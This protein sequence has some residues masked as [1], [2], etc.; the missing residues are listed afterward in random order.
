MNDKKLTSAYL[1]SRV[2]NSD[3]LLNLNI[4]ISDKFGVRDYPYVLIIQSITKK[5]TRLTIYP[6]KK[7]R[8]LKISLFGQNIS[9]DVI[10]ILSKI[11]KNYKI[12]HTSGLLVKQK[13]LFYECYLNLNL[14][15]DV[16]SKDL[17]TS[18]DKIRNIF[19]EVRIEEI[20]LKK[21]ENLTK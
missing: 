5:R 6:T 7:D 21:R 1:K 8:L 16:K 17:K 14:S 11:L 20:T 18:L 4:S 13:Q 10:S 15:D 9:N 2:L 12:I 3:I 19:K